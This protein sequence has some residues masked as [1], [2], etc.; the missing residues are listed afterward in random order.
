MHHSRGDGEVFALIAI[1]CHS[2]GNNLTDVDQNQSFSLQRLK[3]ESSPLAAQQSATPA[4][5][6]ELPQYR[7]PVMCALDGLLN[8][9]FFV[10]PCHYVVS[11]D[12]GLYSS[13]VSFVSLQSS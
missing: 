4:S 13:I 7:F 8:W 10:R 9:I 12:Y 5:S 6:K 1:S 2:S 11:F 3:V